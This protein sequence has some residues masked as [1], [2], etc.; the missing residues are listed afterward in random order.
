MQLISGEAYSHSGT[1]NEDF[2][3]MAGINEV[4]TFMTV[5][6]LSRRVKEW[7][8]SV[9]LISKLDVFRKRGSKNLDQHRS[10]S[11]GLLGDLWE[12]WRTS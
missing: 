9:D 5:R 7:R 10:G 2:R 3:A 4:I 1:G 12:K 11:W 8:Y 6:T